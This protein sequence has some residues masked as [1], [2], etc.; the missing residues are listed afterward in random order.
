MQRTAA[1]EARVVLIAGAT[2][3]LDVLVNSAGVGCGRP[4]LTT[5][6]ESA[7]GHELRFAVNYLA[8]FLLTLRASPRPK[9]TP[10]P[11]T[12]RRGDDSGSSVKS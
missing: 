12:P 2:D 5:R 3:S 1:S 10:R 11:T 8:G 4:A 7:D 6:Q 9:R